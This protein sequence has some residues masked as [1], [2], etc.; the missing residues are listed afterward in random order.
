[1][2]LFR[3]FANA[4]HKINH[5]RRNFTFTC[6]ITPRVNF[7]MFRTL[8]DFNDQPFHATGIGAILIFEGQISSKRIQPTGLWTIHFIEALLAERKS[9]SFKICQ[10]ANIYCQFSNR[11]LSSG[12]VRF[13]SLSDHD[14]PEFVP[15]LDGEV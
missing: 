1:P 4:T 7:Y 11:I 2:S 8:D 14:K 12:I 10:F 3:L 9:V 6:K 13:E 15:L 5:A